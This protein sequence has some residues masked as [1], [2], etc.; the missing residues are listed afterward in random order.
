LFA[1]EAPVILASMD[2][3]FGLFEVTLPAGGACEN[4]L[5]MIALAESATNNDKIGTS[6]EDFIKNF[7]SP[8]VIMVNGIS[9]YVKFFVEF[10]N[11]QS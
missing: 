1:L 9:C 10:D 7:S 2:V 8:K 4:A 5:P 6:V 3:A 11:A